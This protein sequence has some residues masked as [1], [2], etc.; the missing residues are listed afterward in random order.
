MHLTSRS[1]QLI[2]MILESRGPVRIKELA[3]EL[4]VSERTVKYDLESVRSWL[5]QHQVQLQSQPNKGIWIDKDIHDP[6]RLQ[7]LLMN[8]ERVDLLLHPQERMQQLLLVLLLRDDPI[9]IKDLAKK[10]NVSRN[11]V[12]TDL[13]M[14]ESF[15]ENW[16][17]IVERSRSG[18]QLTA[19]EINRR[20]VLENILQEILSGRYMFEIVQGII[21]GNEVPLKVAWVME[22][23]RLSHQDIRSLFQ[24]VKEMAEKSEKHAGMGFTDQAIIGTCIRLW[25]AIHRLRSHRSVLLEANEIVG[26]KK[27]QLFRVYEEI[28]ADLSKQLGVVEMTE[29]E[30]SFI[31]WHGIRLIQPIGKNGTLS[32]FYS[33]TLEL[34]SQV[35]LQTHIEFRGDVHLKEHLLVHLTEKLSKYQPDVAD[36][37]P[38]ISDIIRSDPDMFQA[39]KQ[40]CHEVF[41]KLGIHF[42]DS[43]IGYIALHFLASLKRMQD[44]REFKAL[45]VCGTGRGTSQF[46]KTIL[47]HEIRHLQVIGCCS[48]L[49]LENQLQSLNPDLLISVVQVKAK[50]PVV[51]VHSIPTPEDL[52]SIQKVIT[53]LRSHPLRKKT[54]LSLPSPPSS[55][56][57]FTEEV[58]CKGFELSREILSEMKEDLNEQRAEALTLHLMLMA[59]RVACGST[60]DVAGVEDSPLTAEPIATLRDKLMRILR[61]KNFVLPESEINSILCYFM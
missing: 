56:E 5:Q 42:A 38:L 33:F 23:F 50:V 6:N 14:A 59:N 29:H 3:R 16:N 15:L 17:V 55:M 35:S 51:V 49:G 18:I 47:E 41:S 58:I 34:I 45:V 52:D 37:N 48:A 12:V 25:I 27:L 36:P 54:S 39:V 43:D 30:V 7:N 40:A 11:T 46:L 10:L 31:C 22:K 28:L 61:E 13:S 21:Q 32:D 24:A 57:E 19:T 8:P 2:C 9:K 20:L 26:L 1:Y 44:K 4:Q 53:Q 60:Y